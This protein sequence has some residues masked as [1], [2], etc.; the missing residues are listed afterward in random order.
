MTR[1][2]FKSKHEKAEF[3]KQ[4]P[5]EGL[6]TIYS[7]T[8]LNT[9]EQIYSYCFICKLVKPERAHHCSLCNKCILKMDHHCPWVGNCVGFGNHKL[10]V[11]FCFH[12]SMGCLS[13]G[14][15]LIPR[16]IQTFSLDNMFSGVLYFLIKNATI[17]RRIADRDGMCLRNICRRCN[18]L[19]RC[20]ARNSYHEQLDYD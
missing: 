11:Q 1:V 8:Q 9:Q 7:K 10:F 2:K 6:E 17:G 19:H 12:A 13:L 14:F 3:L 20:Y 5:G 18:R 4:H 15:L 16:L